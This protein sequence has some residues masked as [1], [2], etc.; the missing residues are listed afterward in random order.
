MTLKR[1]A[2]LRQA[3]LMLAG[4]GLT[5]AGLSLFGSHYQ[6]VLAQPT[7]RKLALLVG[8]N[9]YDR[10]MKVP[11]LSG[12]L[13]DVDL[14]RELLIHRFGFH[15]SDILV[16]TDEQAT[17]SNIEAA[18]T[19]HLIE[20]AR[21]TD[22]VVFHF[23]G[24]GRYI[25][26]GATP[27]EI[28]SSA[29]CSQQNTL[30]P[31]DAVLPTTVNPEVSV[32]NDI[33]EDTLFL[34][35]RSLQTD[36]TTA[37]LDTGYAYPGSPLIG[38]LRVRARPNSVQEPLT[39]ADLAFQ[40]RLLSQTNFSRDQVEVQRR[41]SQM[42]GVIL[43]AAKPAQLAAEAQWH[44]FNAGLF[45]YALTQHLWNT[46]PAT[47]IWVNLSRAVAE[48]QQ[49]V[50]K[51]QQPELKG[52]KSHQ[53]VFP[54]YDLSAGEAADG[55]VIATE[56]NGK[57]G[58]LWLS[59]MAP[60]VLEYYDLNSVL[61][62]LPLLS[63]QTEVKQA[64]ALAIPALPPPPA[65]S[66]VSFHPI[67]TGI[68]PQSPVVEPDVSAAAV[69][70]ASNPGEAA[71][72]QHIQLQSLSG[73]TAKGQ[74][75]GSGQ[76]QAGQLV[77]EAIRVLPRNIGLT[78]ALDASL[79]RIERVDATSAFSTMSHISTVVAGEQPADY[80]FAKVQ[81]TTSVQVKQ[82]EGA[83]PWHVLVGDPSQS[84]SSYGLFSL[85]REAVPNTLGEAEEAVKAA[86]LRLHP[87]L[88]VLLASK[89]LALTVNDYSSRLGVSATLE[90]IAPKQKVLMR[91]ET[92]RAPWS[93]RTT[94]LPKVEKSGNL[95]TLPIGSRIQYRI[96][97]YSD[98]PLY[99]ALLGVDSSASPFVFYAT[100]RQ[101]ENPEAKLLV[102]NEVIT[103][104]TTL[105]IPHLSDAFEWLV[106]GPTGLAITYL[107][108]SSQ[109][110]SKTLAAIEAIMRQQQTSDN[111]Q[112]A[113]LPNYLDVVQE[114]FQDLK[115]AGEIAAQV[116]GI[117]KEAFAL[118]VEQWATLRFIYRVI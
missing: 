8:I 91:Q 71:A 85:G 113:A 74:V 27:Q 25:H 68:T 28:S 29:L 66:S 50:G 90:M 100:A 2:F 61:V 39:A 52:Q 79:E 57:T 10:Y 59:G 63:S 73:L 116:A 23:S 89:L 13:T 15:T 18:F 22:V 30:I 105:T 19:A 108:V 48:V 6:Q 94:C 81:V 62:V 56:D 82:P 98:R 88:K 17:R 86:V 43:A 37:V 107:I 67:T 40:A 104:G 20:Q 32:V 38:N 102:K 77:Q 33:L 44:G 24:Y 9:Q 1:R 109:P 96:N 11:A 93:L 76:L 118:D 7:V 55:V 46:T 69:T 87:K 64:K 12:C 34:L 14:Q 5:E 53:D 16:L 92:S 84:Q 72:L 36:Q 106:R 111:Q 47:S 115:Q 31:I 83:S 58:R 41:S 49:R 42:P 117:P 4:L 78:V 35:L 99:L 70:L 112:V 97:N 65:T 103:P 114:I 45:T 51:A 101:T 95:V 60:E 80:L 26:L 54:G 75:L 3:C 110:L 21:P